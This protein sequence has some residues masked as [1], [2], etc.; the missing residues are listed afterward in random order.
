MSSQ[1]SQKP[2]EIHTLLDY[3]IH[4]YDEVFSTNDIAKEV[5][6][7]SVEDRVV[8]LAETQT[9]G[10]GRLER[11]WI[12]PRG[13]IWLSIILRP[14]IGPKEALKITFITSSA[15]AKTIQQ[16]FGLKAEVKW[17]NDVLVNG[18][19]ICGILT[20]TETKEN[21]VEFVVIGIG[22]NANVDLDAF[23]RKLRETA[24]S[25]KHELG[26]EVERKTLVNTLL[27]NFEHRYKGLKRGMWNS[28]LPEWKSLA[29]FLGRK[30]EVTSF[31]EAFV[32]E[33][34]DVDDGGALI[35]KLENGVL[36]R[37]V[38]GDVAIRKQ[39]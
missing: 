21:I 36:K 5:A 7:K 6:K 27:Q 23:P 38:A 11:Q 2:R 34:W 17:P 22:I 29:T 12:S 13:G 4:Y 24:T 8:I 31:D 20:E 15:V 3:K 16:L 33:A 39:V 9:R 32:G 25:L 26:Y 19:K 18:R 37:V 28:L 14:Q 30:V 35:V 10:K 1:N